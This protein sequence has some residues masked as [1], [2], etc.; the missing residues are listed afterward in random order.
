MQCNLQSNSKFTIFV[1]Y[2]V[3]ELWEHTDDINEM[4]YLSKNHEFHEIDKS[5]KE[6]LEQIYSFYFV[7]YTYLVCRRK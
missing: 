3:L 4:V 2:T 7:S 5:Y 6:I 1:S